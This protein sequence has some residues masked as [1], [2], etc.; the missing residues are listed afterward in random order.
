MPF[1][2]FAKIRLRDNPHG[3]DVNPIEISIAALGALFIAISISLGTLESP[4]YIGMR[5][6][7]SIPPFPGQMFAWASAEFTGWYQLGIGFKSPYP[8]DWILLTFY[9]AAAHLVGSQALSK[10]TIVLL[11]AIAILSMYILLRG[12]SVG[13]IGGSCGAIFY[14]VSPVMFNKMISGQLGFLWGYA[15]LPMWF[16]AYRVFRI[17]GSPYAILAA[18]L[19]AAI[20]SAQLQFIVFIIILIILDAVMFP[21]DGRPPLI[22][23]AWIVLAMGVIQ[24][25]TAI[26][27]AQDG[28]ALNT[29]VS[30]APSYDWIRANSPSLLN[31]IML[32]GYV[33]PYFET[34]WRLAPVPSSV[35]LDL[36]YVVV[37]TCVAGAVLSRHRS[38]GRFA[39]VLWLFG[40]IMAAGINAPTFGI[41]PWLYEHVRPLQMFRELYHWAALGAFGAAVLLG[42]CV[43][44]LIRRGVAF[45]TVAVV[46]ASM[47]LLYCWPALNGYWS[48]QLEHVRLSP[49]LRNT[50]TR[51]T[52]EQLPGRTL[53]LPVDQPMKERGARYAGLDPLGYTLP[54]SLWEYTLLP[55]VSQIAESL[56]TGDLTGVEPLLRYAGVSAIVIRKEFVSELPEYTYRKY[57]IFKRMYRSGRNE[58]SVLH[59]GWKTSWQNSA[60]RVFRPMR[61]K[62]GLVGSERGAALLSPDARILAS[63]PLSLSPVFAS[64]IEKP[65]GIIAYAGDLDALVI[66]YLHREHN[67]LNGLILASTDAEQ[68]WSPVDNW[69]FYYNP[70]TQV[71]DGTLLSLKSGQRLRV[72]LPFSSGVIL[73][74]YVVSPRGGNI[75]LSVGRVI[76]IITTKSKAFGLRTLAI[77]VDPARRLEI[78]NMGGE[79]LLRRV[80]FTEKGDYL[81]AKRHVDALIK[82]VPY[83]R[84]IGAHAARRGHGNR[85]WHANISFHHNATWTAFWGRVPVGTGLLVLREHFDPGWKLTVGRGKQAQHVEGDLFDNAWLLSSDDIGDAFR[86]EYRP[87]R[88]VSAAHWVALALFS[89]GALILVARIGLVIMR[90]IVPVNDGYKRGH[91]SSN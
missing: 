21:R 78:I 64:R 80:V 2:L 15:L 81:R 9:A 43:D 85:G 41:I 47:E 75:R 44:A 13:R 90:E 59:L 70:F 79:Q 1:S 49:G 22:A 11:V 52:R 38:I 46:L 63:L 50:Y 53:W 33:T 27:L 4:G 77:R 19:L 66:P 91:I 8:N 14:A 45:R 67:L 35:G 26:G 60:T 28:E 57:P 88:F 87:A 73:I 16:S 71:Y 86:I 76:R 58:K 32:R 42:L 12:A 20:C 61:S 69:W 31:A 54:P 29:A 72:D 48:Y 34:A 24:A 3:N 82:N 10:G 68:S 17:K 37:L 39:F 51:L 6:D 25:G 18:S 23:A 74:G 83:L 56:R 36:G 30:L 89:I 65:T 5:H 40:V 84:I 7:W 55:P 62:G